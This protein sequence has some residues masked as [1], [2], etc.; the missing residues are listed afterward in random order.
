MATNVENAINTS[1][2]PDRIGHYD[3]PFLKPLDEDLLHKIFKRYTGIMTVEDG[4]IN[5]GLG[6]S[7]LQFANT[8]HYKQTIVVKGIPD[9]F[10]EQGSIDQLQELSGLDAPSLN[11]ALDELFLV[12][13]DC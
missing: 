2:D 9:R 8:H 11:R 5:G 10:I 3:L 12:L 1:S 6:S 13:D 7:I 4:T